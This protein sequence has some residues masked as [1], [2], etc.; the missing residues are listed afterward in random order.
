MT[1]A[2][3]A[4]TSCRPHFC[5]CCI[6]G[7]DMNRSKKSHQT[8]EEKPKNQ[9]YG[10]QLPTSQV[11]VHG[12]SLEKPAKVPVYGTY[13]PPAGSGSQ[14]DLLPHH[15]SFAQVFK[16]NGVQDSELRNIAETFQTELD[17][18]GECIETQ[19]G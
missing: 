4:K 19:E 5:L 8:E 3:N 18:D 14:K 15:D 9:A 17:L 7:L 12:D 2:G 1:D 11:S 13:S 10:T 6:K 16:T